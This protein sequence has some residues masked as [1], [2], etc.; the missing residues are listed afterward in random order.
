MEL[1]IEFMPERW[2]GISVSGDKVVVVDAEVPEEGQIVLQ[3]DATWK[4]QGGNKAAAYDVMLRQACDYF[5]GNGVSK[6]LVKASALPRNAPKLGL[7]HSAELRGVVQAAAAAAGCEVKVI[8]KATLSRNF[9]D[10][11]VDEYADDD[12]FWETHF[13]GED[14]RRGSREAALMIVAESGRHE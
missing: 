9:G 6:V 12:D 14:L 5:R 4:M 2:V 7:L 3:N 8:A 10:R 11:K 13:T 1:R